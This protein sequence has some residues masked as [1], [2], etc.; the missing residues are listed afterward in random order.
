M[1]RTKHVYKTSEIPHLWAHQKQDSAR[2]PQGNLFFEGKVLYSYRTNYPI[3]HIV[4][5]PAGLGPCVLIQEDTYS[6]TTAKH[7][8]LARR[9]V[10]HMTAFTV[11]FLML[12][13]RN[14]ED[15]E[16]NLAWYEEQIHTREGLAVRARSQAGWKHEALDRMIHEANMFCEYFGL[17]RRFTPRTKD[18]IQESL[19]KAEASRKLAQAQ[20][21]RKAQETIDAWKYGAQVH[22]PYGINDTY[23]RVEGDELV[24]S[25]G[26]RV[27]I[28][29]ARK[30]LVFVRSIRARGEGYTRNGHTIHIGH[31]A[32]DSVDSLG[33][34]RAGCH[35]ITYAEIERVAPV[36]ELIATDEI[37][38]GGV[39]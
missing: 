1:K 18:E 12:G 7:I 3:A 23:L 10:S 11:P 31:Y 22:I 16:A 27:P 24:T 39:V 35:Y 4:D 34:L 17:P 28:D 36:V 29:H 14:M 20:K 13:A 5:S 25:K 32:I 37:P 19:R 2:N 9:A 21:L 38:R 30:A 26:A 15:V 33:N 6:N 8:G